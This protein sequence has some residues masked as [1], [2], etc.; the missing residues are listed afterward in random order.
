MCVVF[1]TIN[2]GKILWSNL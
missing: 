1:K 2:Q